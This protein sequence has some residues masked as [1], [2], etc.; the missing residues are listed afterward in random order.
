MCSPTGNGY[1]QGSSSFREDDARRE[2][3]EMALARAPDPLPPHVLLDGISDAR[4][5]VPTKPRL[6]RVQRVP[7]DT[8]FTGVDDLRADPNDPNFGDYNIPP[9]GNHP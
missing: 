4:A 5:P 3:K 7:R 2:I 9:G 6:A 8:N 1:V